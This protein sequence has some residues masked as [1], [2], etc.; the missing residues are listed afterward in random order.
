MWEVEAGSETNLSS[1]LATGTWDSTTR[2]A[3]VTGGIVR[4][5]RTHCGR[6]SKPEGC[7]PAAGKGNRP[8]VVCRNDG[9]AFPEIEFVTSLQ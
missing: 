3:S 1:V 8:T 7:K 9:A 5:T 6:D 2:T 4:A